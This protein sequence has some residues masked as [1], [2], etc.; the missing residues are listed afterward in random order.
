MAVSVPVLPTNLHESFT[1]YA[2]SDNSTS[3]V[4]AG[5]YVAVDDKV[6][7]CAE[8]TTDDVVKVIKD[9]KEVKVDKDSSNEAFGDQARIVTGEAK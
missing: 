1:L 4:T 8:L 5:G 6:I 2:A 9:W 3:G 7:I